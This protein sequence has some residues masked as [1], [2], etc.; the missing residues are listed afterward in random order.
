MLTAILCVFRK[1]F[2]VIIIV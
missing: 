1:S 2:P